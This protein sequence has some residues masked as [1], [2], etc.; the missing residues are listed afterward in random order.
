MGAF[1]ITTDDGSRQVMFLVVMCIFLS[2]SYI[3]VSLRYALPIH[4]P[5]TNCSLTRATASTVATTISEM[6]VLTTISWLAPSPLL[7][8]WP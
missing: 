5:T 1:I 6:S 7:P 3:V 4:L 2:G 8:A